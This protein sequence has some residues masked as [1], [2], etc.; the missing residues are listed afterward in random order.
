M[1]HWS[2]AICSSSSAQWR[3]TVSTRSP[4]GSTTTA[5]P[6][7]YTG[8]TPS[9]H[10]PGVSE[11]H[12]H[13]WTRE[14]PTPFPPW[15]TGPTPSAHP[16]QHSGETPY[17]PDWTGPTTTAFPPWY[18]GPTPSAHPPGVSGE[19]PTPYPP[20]Y[21]GETPTP[22]G[23]YSNSGESPTP[24]PPAGRVNSDAIPTM[25]HW[26][27]AICSSSSAQWRDT[28]STRLDGSHN[29]GIPAMVHWSNAICSSSWCKRRI[30]YTV[31]TRLH[32]RDTNT[33]W[34]LFK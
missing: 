32:W 28:V 14:T 20:G 27:N 7:W 10:P 26:S 31:S 3:D 4:G 34:A 17:P 15:Y 29:H 24:Y 2:N 23:P 11:N 16:P 25:V 6:P 13:R 33:C 30:T 22:A 12:L 1:V 18:T 21:T 5:F 9:A 8:P 19:S